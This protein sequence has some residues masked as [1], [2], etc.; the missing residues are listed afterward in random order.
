MNAR[1]VTMADLREV[2]GH[3]RTSGL[4]LVPPQVLA[5]PLNG[6]AVAVVGAGGGCGATTVALA[7]A[8]ELSQARVIEC[9]T[10]PLST[11]AAATTAELG[12]TDGGWQLGLREGTRHPLM[13]QRAPREAISPA[14]LPPPADYG[15]QHLTSTV[16][17]VGWP[18]SQLTGWLAASLAEAAATVVVTSATCHGMDHLEAALREIEART[19]APIFAVAGGAEPKRWPRE[20]RASTGPRTRRLLEVGALIP[21]AEDRGLR[22]RGLTPDPL[23]PAVTATGHELSRYLAPLLASAQPDV[24]SD[25]PPDEH[26]GSGWGQLVAVG[27]N[28]A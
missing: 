22:L 4:W 25:V 17:D 1:V 27:R 26:C 14:K 19:Q 13:I 8:Q 23:P 9:R 11:L 21:L 20:L 28:P 6:M 24:Q 10:A 16:L 7:L 12:T 5:N 2:C 15:D 3:H 18:L